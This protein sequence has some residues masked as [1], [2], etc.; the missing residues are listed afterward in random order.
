M[1]FVNRLETCNRMMRQDNHE[2]NWQTQEAILTE[3]FASPK[4]EN[5]RPVL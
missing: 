5:G 1:V 3:L 2:V 4:L